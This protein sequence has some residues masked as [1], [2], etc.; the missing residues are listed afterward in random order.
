MISDMLQLISLVASPILPHLFA[1]LLLV[2]LAVSVKH[3]FT[4]E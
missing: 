1:Y 4:K 2:L 3:G